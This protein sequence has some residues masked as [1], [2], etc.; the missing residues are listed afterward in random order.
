MSKCLTDSEVNAFVDGVSENTVEIVEHLNNCSACYQDVS[1]L[2]NLIEENKDA[3]D[4]LNTSYEKMVSVHL[5]GAYYRR[6][7]KYLSHF[8]KNFIPSSLEGIL[9]SSIGQNTASVFGFNRYSVIGIAFLVAMVAVTVQSPFIAENDTS[10]K[11]L[12][13]ASHHEKLESDLKGK[14]TD[15]SEVEQ[16]KSEIKDYESDPDKK[17][18][19]ELGKIVMKMKAASLFEEKEKLKIYLKDLISNPLVN[20]NDAQ[21]QEEVGDINNEDVNKII[22]FYLK[23]IDMK[24]KP[25]FDYGLEVEKSK[26]QSENTISN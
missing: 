21:S 19:V 20:K 1:E 3:Y 14:E 5:V 8:I 24:L 7:K 12:I 15:P 9:P 11:K 4:Q 22:D 17:N 26:I 2:M 23:G 10:E 25:Y 16:F 18:A 6:Y 13:N